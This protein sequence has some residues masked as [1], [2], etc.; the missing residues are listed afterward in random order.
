MSSR[1]KYIAPKRVEVAFGR[2]AAD[3]YFA[4]VTSLVGPRLQVRSLRGEE[5]EIVLCDAQ[6]V[7]DALE[8]L[9]ITRFSGRPLLFVNARL[10]LLAIAIGPEAPPAQIGWFPHAVRLGEHGAVEMLGSDDAQPSWL[11]FETMTDDDERAR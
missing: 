5:R 2:D 11:L 8:R 6:A 7:A 10:R 1:T 3:A 4:V 9:D